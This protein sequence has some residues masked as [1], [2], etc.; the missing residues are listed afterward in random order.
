[1]RK[2]CFVTGTRAEYGL[3]S[4]LMRLVENGNS[5]QLQIV[6]TNMHLLPEYGETYREIE[7]DGF[8]VDVKVPMQRLSDNALGIVASMSEEILG[9]GHAYEKLKPD[10]VVLLGDRYEILVAAE[11]ALIYRIPVVHIHGGE[12]TEGAFDDAIRHAVTKMSNLHF[13]ST[14]EYRLRVIQMGEHPDRVFNVGSLGVENIKS[15]KLMKKDELERS[16]DF[17]ILD[18]TILLTYHPETLG[19]I[20]VKDSID[21]L[22]S[23]LDSIKDLNIIFTMPNSDTGRDGVAE[24]IKKYVE[25]HPD[26]SRAF[27][28]LGLRRYLSTL[29]Y[30]KA[31]VGNSSSGIIEVPSMGIPTLNIGDR[32]KG[33]THGASVYDCGSD[34][35]SIVEGLRIVLSD[36]FRQV[37]GTAANPYEKENT[38]ENIFKVISSYP[39]DK[40]RHK[41]FYD[42]K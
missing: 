40:L 12:I 9:M 17:R 3:L 5:T 28:S 1:M 2:I 14:E 33:R 38:A 20:S 25:K 42:I 36:K 27:K 34:T 41:F 10:M 19:D 30:V 4:H 29:H 18:N 6:A 22:L 37:A 13:T 35:A 24:S 32:Q 11:V 15:V 26:R 39:L 21:S 8:S 23:A 31:V 7:S 16:L